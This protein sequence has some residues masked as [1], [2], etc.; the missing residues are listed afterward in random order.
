MLIGASCQRKVML[1]T[2]PESALENTIP[3][4]SPL[5]QKSKRRIWRWV[6]LGNIFLFS[7]FAYRCTSGIMVTARNSDTAVAA[8]HT[9]LNSGAY[10]TIYDSSDE[11]FQRSSKEQ[12]LLEFFNAVHTK[13]GNT[14]TSERRNIDV[15]ATTNGTFA[16]VTYATT[17]ERGSA[18]ETFTWIVSD[19]K[20]KLVGYNIN[21]R[22]LIVK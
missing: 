8:F 14:G 10:K 5:E 21:S 9:D 2:A 6:V 20:L 4:P 18:I 1:E 7:F 19:G 12:E 16:N 11:R 17:F 3:P 15:N 22:E 13:L